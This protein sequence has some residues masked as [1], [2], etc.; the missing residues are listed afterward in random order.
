M[1]A[2]DTETQLQDH[3]GEVPRVGE[4]H[5]SPAV[6]PKGT[7]FQRLKDRTKGEIPKV[8]RTR[9]RTTPQPHHTP[10]IKR[11]TGSRG[12]SS[13]DKKPLVPKL[14]SQ[15]IELPITTSQV[16]PT[17]SGSMKSDSDTS[18]RDRNTSTVQPADR[19]VDPPKKVKAQLREISNPIPTNLDGE[20]GPT[21]I[22]SIS[23][24][25]GSA[26]PQTPTPSVKVTIGRIEVRAIHPQDTTP[27]SPTPVEPGPSLSLEDYLKKR[28]G[29][30]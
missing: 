17:D 4:T 29:A 8:I 3:P 9:A 30:S 2:A 13:S 12:S 20:P 7:T 28:N 23:E 24:Y 18:V 22:R 16:L 19:S 14:K 21:Q 15:G 26:P 1:Y 11:L 27:P 10:E 5:P 6:D 25:P